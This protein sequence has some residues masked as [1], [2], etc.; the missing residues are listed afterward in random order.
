MI[1][2]NP[3]NKDI[4]VVILGV[5]Y[6]VPAKGSISGVSQ[7]TAYYW[8]NKLHGFLIVENESESTK[9]DIKAKVQEIIDSEET[10]KPEDEVTEDEVVEEKVESTKKAKGSK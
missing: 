5:E 1:V 4:S 6:T 2:T 9:K 7:E 8:Q 3:T 10:E